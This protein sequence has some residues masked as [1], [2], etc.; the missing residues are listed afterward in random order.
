MVKTEEKTSYE[1]LKA[2][3][4]NGEIQQGQR[5][6]ESFLSEMMDISR[7][8]VREAVQQLVHEGFIER[9]GK[10][11][12]LIKEYNEK[13]IIDLYNYR[14][15]LD[16]MMTRLFTQRADAS[17]LY[18]LEMNVQT[19]NSRLK[20]MK[21][22]VIA[23]IDLEFHR[24][25]ARGARNPYMEHQHEIILEK[26]LYVSFLLRKM[27]NDEAGKN[28]SIENQEDTYREHLK[29]FTEIQSRDPD[30]AETAARESI[31]NGLIKA[32]Q[33]LSKRL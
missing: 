29:I 4:L 5:M 3:I 19:M 17:L 16:G 14:E 8:P 27:N 22:D 9:A 26:V 12:Y 11:G 23:E 30:R 2:L 28:V 25:I 7:I 10:S 24:I 1:R 6:T 32:L 13:D 15:A 21:P 33:S 20:D 18:F 31:Q